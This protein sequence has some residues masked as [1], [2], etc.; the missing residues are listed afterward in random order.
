MANVTNFV[1]KQGENM[2]NTQVKVR[3]F[4]RGGNPTPVDGKKVKKSEIQFSWYARF[5]DPLSG[6][7]SN[8]I[9]V[10][11]LRKKIGSTDFTPIKTRDEALAICLKAVE[12]GVALGSSV[13]PSFIQ[14]CKDFWDFDS[15]KYVKDLLI[16]DENAISRNYTHNMKKIIEN[17][18]VDF[19]PESR[20][21]ASVKR[22]DI[23]NIKRK[24]MTEGKVAPA[25]VKKILKAVE[26]PL[27][28]AVHEGLISNNPAEGI[29]VRV[30]NKAEERGCYSVEQLQTLLNYLDAHKS[31]SLRNYRLYLSVQLAFRTGLRLGEIRALRSERITFTQSDIG[32]AP[33]LVEVSES[34]ASRTGC[35][36]TKG[37]R[38]RSVPVP[39]WLAK[40]LVKLAHKC[41][42]K[43]N[44]LVFWGQRENAPLNEHSMRDH[45]LDVLKELGIQ[46]DEKGNP[47][48][49]HSF[50]HFFNSTI[51]LNS[52]LT[53]AE[54]RSIV[55]HQS[56]DMTEHYTHIQENAL[57][58]SGTRINSYFEKI[59]GA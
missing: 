23:E 11:K 2:V 14:Y 39:A 59:L 15:S 1:T 9:A 10:S 37:K 48:G 31:E 3:L 13:N 27:A 56:E 46:N 22:S 29:S 21:L 32:Q 24:L 35:K 49:F 36:G 44:T 51:R 5:T 19:I 8:P 30:G 41:P 20:K 33:A 34:W 4:K 16:E 54:L 25:T 57:I 50:R 55:G 42:Y 6:V 52:V 45:L 43:G 40:E 53:D 26:Q 28:Y 58:A 38:A 47:L 18:I 17:H 7:E 12:L